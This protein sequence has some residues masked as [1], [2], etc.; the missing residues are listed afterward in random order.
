M[1]LYASE[2]NIDVDGW[3]FLSTDQ[4][5][6]KSF[7]DDL[8]FIFFDSPKGFDHL[9]QTTLVDVDGRIYRQIYGTT[10]E[11]PKLIEP[12]KELVF[13]KRSENS[14][15]KNWINN[16]RLFC[17]IYDPHSGRYAF[18]YSIFLGIAIGILMLGSI[19]A[20]I[21]REWRHNNKNRYS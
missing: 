13:E 2:R 20:F 11:H 5:T 8:G 1:H 19:A 6:I 7:S 15:V 14:L 9:S 16:I 4:E 17:T 10:Y 12:L 21:V 3:D 18:D